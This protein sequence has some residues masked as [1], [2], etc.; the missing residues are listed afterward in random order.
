MQNI[1]QLLLEKIKIH[2]QKIEEFFQKKFQ[3]TPEIFYNSVDLRHCGFK[4]APVD[5]NCFPAGFNNLAPSSKEKAKVIADDFLNKNFPLA[6]KILLIP[7]SHT[8]N[9]RYLENV[10]NLCEILAYKREILIGTLIPEFTANTNLTLENGHS[11]TLHPLAKKSDKICTTDGFIPDLIILN[12]DLTNGIP[13]ILQNTSTTIIPSPTI[14]WHNR[15]KSHHFDIYNNLA[16]ELAQ[17]LEIDPWLISSL[18]KSYS[19]ID[20]K[21]K[22]GIDDLAQGVDELLADLAK[23]YQQYGI[24]E[25]PY[26]YVK[27]DSG[28][29]GIGVWPVFSAKEVA[30]IN[31][32]E[33]N[34]MNMLK[35]SVQ[36]TK[37]II[38]EGI[39][40]I[41]K[42]NNKVAEPLIYLINAKIIGNLFRTNEARDDKSSLNSPGSN[43]FDLQNLLENQVQLGLEKNK[44]IEIYSLIARLAALASA[45][46]NSQ[47]KI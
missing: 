40:T 27:A 21:E 15:T 18:H 39:K 30:E 29:Y 13:E 44:I 3:Q 14:G 36:N 24:D 37:V 33:R 31:K 12:N 20:F 7:E 11:L 45:I 38:Q 26:C 22:K 6:K 34:K 4:I 32:K 41:D 1:T 17:I 43:F 2:Q 19:D 16:I 28:T 8:R 46:E 47:N 23:K 9:L 25:Q 5:T 35:G 42:I 10:I